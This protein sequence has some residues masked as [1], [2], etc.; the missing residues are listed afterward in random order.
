[1]AA[2][3]INRVFHGVG[4]SLGKSGSGNNIIF[5]KEFTMKKQTKSGL[6]GILAIAIGIGLG[7]CDNPSNG[8]PAKTLSADAALISLSVTYSAGE[9]VTTEAVWVKDGADWENH[10]FDAEHTAYDFVIPYDVDSV[11]ITAMTNSPAAKV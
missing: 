5:R 10:E 8:E 7:S 9:N 11:T 6:A 4:F 1:M 3:T 2:G